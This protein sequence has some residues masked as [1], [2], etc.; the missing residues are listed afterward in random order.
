MLQYPAILPGWHS[1]C[2]TAQPQNSGRPYGHRDKSV[3]SKSP[4]VR[5]SH[6]CKQGREAPH[7]F[8]R[9]SSPFCKKVGDFDKKGTSN[10]SDFNGLEIPRVYHNVAVELFVFSLK[11][12]INI[13]DKTQST[14]LKRKTLFFAESVEKIILGIVGNCKYGKVACICSHN[15]DMIR[16]QK[17]NGRRLYTDGTTN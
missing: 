9:L 12:R 14:F 4:P 7:F 8:G 2:A 5:K 17:Q 1:G 11:S 13:S 15:H 6:F 3:T 10:P 16:L